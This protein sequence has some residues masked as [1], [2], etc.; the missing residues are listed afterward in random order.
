MGGGSKTDNLVKSL[1]GL[2]IGDNPTEREVFLQCPKCKLDVFDSGLSNELVCKK[3]SYE[4]SSG[5]KKDKK[6]EM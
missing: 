5:K 2:R 4:L 1:Q 6:S 3:C